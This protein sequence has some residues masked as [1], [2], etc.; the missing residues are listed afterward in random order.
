MSKRTF[1]S[2][3]GRAWTASLV[4]LPR[5]TTTEPVQAVLR[6]ASGD[7]ALDLDDWPA[8]WVALPEPALIQL[9]RQAKPPR[10][11]LPVS[12]TSAAPH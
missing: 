7:L 11:G 8:D 6:F 10:L 5:M 2:P 12:R 9:V 3:S 4:D 1:T